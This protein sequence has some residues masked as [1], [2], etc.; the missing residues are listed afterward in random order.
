MSKYNIN[1]K[2]IG[3][4]RMV[5]KLRLSICEQA[6]NIINYLLGA[7][8]IPQNSSMWFGTDFYHVFGN[9][10]AIL[11]MHLSQF[12]HMISSITHKNHDASYSAKVNMVKHALNDIYILKDSLNFTGN[13]FD[14]IS[15]KD[16]VNLKVKCYSGHVPHSFRKNIQVR[17]MLGPGGPPSPPS[18]SSYPHYPPQSTQ[19]THY[20]CKY[21]DQTCIG[22]RDV[23]TLEDIDKN[24]INNV[25]KVDKK[26]YDADELQKWLVNNNNLP[27]NR[28][29]YT[30]KELNECVE[31]ATSIS[32]ISSSVSSTIMELLTPKISQ[33]IYSS[34]I[35]PSISPSI[36]QNIYPSSI[37]P[38]SISPF[39]TMQDPY[40]YKK[41]KTY[42]DDD[43]DDDL[44]DDL[45]ENTD[46]NYISSYNNKPKKK[47]SKKKS[48]KKK[49][50]KKKSSK[51][52]SS[53][54]KNSKK[55]S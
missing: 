39:Q 3:G 23:I 55:K 54:K 46:S 15:I 27:H 19:S 11:N 53:K 22:D 38:P 2:Q 21:R 6:N 30:S 17:E 50:S 20:R 7:L 31:K 16:I 34:S 14:I 29:R 8:F 24:N 49:S 36:S 13:H 37:Y 32:P 47:S 18:S 43:D 5:T 44:F 9:E 33:N 10:S 35:S 41:K 1:Y 48:S 40:F 4:N 51:K 12:E 42:Y 52:K 26:C 45:V 28:Q 25:V